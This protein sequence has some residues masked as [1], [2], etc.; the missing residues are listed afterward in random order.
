MTTAVSSTDSSSQTNSVLQNY[1]NQQA[2]NVAADQAAAASAS[3]STSSAL[4]SA[5]SASSI[6]SNF[7]TFINILTTQLKSQ[8]PTNATDPNQFTQELVQFAGVEQQLNTNN[9]LQTMINLQKASGGTTAALGYMGQY[10]ESTNTTSGQLSVQSG[11]SEFG[12]TLP[13]AAANV[14]ISVQNSAGTT[15]AT[16]SGPTANGTNYVTWNGQDSNGNQLADGAYTYTVSAT[17]S[18]GNAISLTDYRMIGKVTGLAS[19]SD[20]TTSLYL[21]TGVSATTS[22]IDSVFT[23]SS[24][25]SSTSV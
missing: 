24:L 9:D 7:N 11:T 12:Y 1:L 10:V 4:A 16:L 17:D 3:T 5:T 13:S 2:A 6:G 8:D 20:G 14:T 18:G 22:T 19:N 25:P 21:G 23:S 15:V